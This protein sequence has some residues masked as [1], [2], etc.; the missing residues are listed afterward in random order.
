M[1]ICALAGGVAVLSCALAQENSASAAQFYVSNAGR[2]TWSG[3]LADPDIHSADGPFA[4]LARAQQA[5]RGARKAGDEAVTVSIRGG[6]YPQA[7]SLRFGPEDSG[8][9]A[10]PVIWQAYGNESVSITGAKQVS[11]FRPL[12]HAD[13]RSRLPEAARAHVLELDLKSQGI[14]EFGQLRAR[15]FL[16]NIQPAPMELFFGGRPM[17]LARWPNSGWAVVKDALAP[18]K[19]TF[20]YAENEPGRIKSTKDVWIHGYFTYTYADYWEP[21]VS[22]DASRRQI[23][24]VTPAPRGTGAYHKDSRY[25]IINALEELDSP[26]EYYIDRDTGM[27]YFWPPGDLEKG[28]AYVSMLEDPVIRGRVLSNV[29]FKGLTIE[30]SRGAGIEIAGRANVALESCTLRNLGSVGASIGTL[31]PD[32][33]WALY[34]DTTMTNDPGV[35]NGLEGCRIYDVGEGGVILGGGDRKTLAAGA[36]YVRGCEIHDFNRWVQTSRPGVFVYGAGNDVSSN[37]IDNG[38][39]IGIYI[40]GN[41]NIVEYNELHDLCTQTTDAGAIYMGRDPS[42]R[43]NLIRYN[44]IHDLTGPPRT[45][46]GISL[47]MGVYLDDVSS[48]ATVEGNVFKNV[49]RPVY[50]GGGRDNLIANNVF[51]DCAIGVHVDDRGISRDATYERRLRAV[52]FDHPPYSTRYPSLASMLRDQPNAPK[53]NK[54]VRNVFQGGQWLDIAP[55]IPA[56]MVDVEDN[57]TEGARFDG[58]QPAPGSR[59]PGFQLLPLDKMTHSTR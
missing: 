39:H 19:R 52:N 24:T 30:M 25:Q 17:T 28:K 41:D 7:E 57:V 53:G 56:G 34:N 42:Q 40:N 16:R 59:P 44:Y 35:G 50:I 31:W 8:T 9:I 27:L 48:G 51:I 20:V 13:V 46:P 4:T 43:G 26:G 18:E 6:V 1:L 54:V 10:N 47:V 3:R 29:R 37:E 15:G 5:V 55:T 33:Y 36:N 32:L 21:V 2:D 14:D 45:R 12:A 58:L 22:I 49:V 38:P 11:G 23:S